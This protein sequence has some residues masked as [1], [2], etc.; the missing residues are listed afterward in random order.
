MLF[1]IMRMCDALLWSGGHFSVFTPLT[2]PHT[3]TQQALSQERRSIRSSPF[4]VNNA[5][6]YCHV[7]LVA[8]NPR[9]GGGYLSFVYKKSHSK[10]DPW[11]RGRKRP[12]TPQID[13][14]TRGLGAWYWS[15]FLR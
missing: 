3:R 9:M 13:T 14:K 4:E 1:A 2:A 8:I 12:A 7:S 10:S 15:D 5:W 11:G 6:P